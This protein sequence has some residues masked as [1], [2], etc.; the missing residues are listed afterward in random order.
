MYQIMWLLKRKP[1]TT[2]EHFRHHYETSHSILGQKYFGHLILSY[3]RNYNSA[4]AKDGGGDRA[5]DYD[6]VTIW[7][8]PDKAAVD[9]I[10]RIMADPVIGPIFLEDETHFLDSRETRL[11]RC[12][13]SDTGPGD[14]AGWFQDLASAG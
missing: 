7:E 8:M 12:D 2:H 9:E 6:C 14:G 4:R 5:S 13:L 3:K 11:V 1:G 10:Y